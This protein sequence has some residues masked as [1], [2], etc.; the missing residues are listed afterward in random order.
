MKLSCI[1]AILTAS[2]IV[3]MR[4]REVYL[5]RFRLGHS[6]PCAPF[7]SG[8]SRL[9]RHRPFI[10]RYLACDTEIGARKLIDPLQFFGGQGRSLRRI[11]EFLQLRLIVNIRQ[12]AGHPRI[13]EQPLQ[14]R[15]TERAIRT[16]QKLQAS[17]SSSGR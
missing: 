8:R 4:F 13:G 14:C 5:S 11:R 16:N 12:A 15:L 6:D 1:A 2:R 3:A 17:R 7:L 9:A 10:I